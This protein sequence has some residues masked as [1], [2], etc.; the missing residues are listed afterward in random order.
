MVALTTRDSHNYRCRMEI[1]PIAQDGD[2]VLV[3]V[4]VVPNASTTNIVGRHGDR[5]RVRVAAPPEGG[6]ANDAVCGLF[7]DATG[8]R[9]ASVVAGQASRSKTVRLV[10]VTEGVVRATLLPD[11]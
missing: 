6:R 10:G 9:A 8:V 2:D 5:I 11:T 4:L 3:R 1:L 7:T